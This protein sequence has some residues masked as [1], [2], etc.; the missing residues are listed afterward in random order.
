[1]EDR[2]PPPYYRCKRCGSKEHYCESVNCPALKVLCG[3][4]K[5]RG[6]LIEFCLKKARQREDENRS[7]RPSTSRDRPSTSRDHPSTS[8]DHQDQPAS[9]RKLILSES[10][11]DDEAEEVV[12]NLAQ[13]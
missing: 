5:T 3:F 2:K 9:K 11:S 10:S 7:D 13:E 6:H 12:V 1:M 4:C 8:R